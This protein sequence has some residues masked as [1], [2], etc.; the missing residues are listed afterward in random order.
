MKYRK[1][2]D[3]AVHLH[4]PTSDFL[5]VLVWRPSGYV[6]KND[7]KAATSEEFLFDYVVDLRM[8]KGQFPTKNRKQKWNVNMWCVVSSIHPPGTI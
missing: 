4:N 3:S 7:S 8:K 6:D 1:L 2:N 5:L